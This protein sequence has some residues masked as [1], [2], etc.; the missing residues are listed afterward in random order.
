[1]VRF[2]HC[3]V[4]AV[5]CLVLGSAGLLRGQERIDLDALAKAG[6]LSSARLK[7]APAQWTIR[8]TTA[9]GA[10]FGVRVVAAASDFEARIL[11]KPDSKDPEP[12]ARV[13]SH[14]GKWAAEEYGGLKGI[15]LPWEP[16]FAFEVVALL[17]S[18]AW[19]PPYV[20]KPEHS[21]LGKTR[22]TVVVRAPLSGKQRELAE[23]FL[24]EA[25][26][27]EVP[28]NSELHRNLIAIRKR[29][30]EGN[31]LR[32]DA[33][34]GLLEHLV[35]ANV[36]VEYEAVE[37]LSA[38][39]EIPHLVDYPD[40]SAPLP[41]DR[42]GLIMVGHAGAWR[43]GYPEMDSGGQL[44]NMD[45]GK[46]LRIPFKGSSCMPGCF[47]DERDKVVVTARENDGSGV[48]LYLVNLKTGQMLR[49]GGETFAGGICEFPVLSPDGK[50]LAVTCSKKRLTRQLYFLNFK[51]KMPEAI[52]MPADIQSLSWVGDGGALIGVVRETT[53]EGAESNLMR[54]GFDGSMTSLRKEVGPLASVVGRDGKRILFREKDLLWYSCDLKGGEVK[55]VG[56]G[57]KGLTFPSV[58]PDGTHVVMLEQD[59]KKRSWPV[60]IELESGKKFP[61]KVEP[62]RW[63]LPAWR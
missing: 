42:D 1:M 16:P 36:E 43:P 54:I 47:V 25:E 48:G 39:P 62:G 41:K 40:F 26:R 31:R 30:K 17:L 49:L 12:F 35:L 61:I 52:G 24:E 58:N 4:L 28:V 37:W 13:V 20:R 55:R 45:T 34:T 15:Y 7:T 11:L 14:S 6:K 22:E 18:E 33:K 60:V 23:S 29:L 32:V 57:L 53:K 44:L 19:P 46:L 8:A 2:P 51:E 21:V 59:E 3:S 56:D 9:T 27:S 5:L 38:K 10:K 63:L 50:T